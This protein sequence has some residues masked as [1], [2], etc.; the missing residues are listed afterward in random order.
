MPCQFNEISTIK[1]DLEG[2]KR[3]VEHDILHSIVEPSVVR[4]F[5]EEGLMY[6]IQFVQDTFKLADA[7]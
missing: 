4:A 7:G 3:L 2:Q 1:W 5:V 6:A